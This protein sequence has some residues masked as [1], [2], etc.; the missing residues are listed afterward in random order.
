MHGMYATTRFPGRRHVTH[1]PTDKTGVILVAAGLGGG[2]SPPE[3]GLDPLPPP[4]PPPPPPPTHYTEEKKMGMSICIYIYIYICTIGTTMLLA[5]RLA[6]PY[7][8]HFW[9]AGL[10][11]WWQM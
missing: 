3:H 7:Y 9:L 11:G 2:G 4:P 10:R 5:R 6:N 8:T 1:P